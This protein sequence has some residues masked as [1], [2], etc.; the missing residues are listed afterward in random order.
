MFRPIGPVVHNIA[1]NCHFV[2]ITMANM[3]YVFMSACTGAGQ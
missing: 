3:L 1:I 2:I